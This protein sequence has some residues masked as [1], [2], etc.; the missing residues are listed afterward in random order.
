[1]ERTFAMKVFAVTYWLLAVLFLYI[2][3]VLI[4]PQL[5]K[6][7]DQV[8]PFLPL[9]VGFLAIFVVGAAIATFW[10]GARRRDWIWLALLVPPALFL[11][12]NAPFIPFS[13]THPADIA[14]TAVV[15]LVIGTIVLVWA[16]VTAFREVRSGSLASSSGATRAR[17]AVAVVAGFTIGA[18]ATG[19]LASTA[20]GGGGSVVAAPTTTATLVA[21]GTKYLTTS[22]A[23]TASDV[24]GIFVENKD[25]FAHSFDIDA[26]NLHV[27]IAAN[28]TVALSVKPAGAGS[29]EFY[30]AVPGHKEAG[31]AGTINVQ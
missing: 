11:L 2:L 15:P 4:L 16:G 3:V 23:M 22:Y 25:S 21:L 24:L 12:M 19:Y 5:A 6:S 27:Q 13:V 9:I 17:V 30:C 29:L 10:G 20:A 18:F 28:S 1:M 26:L 31:M 8:G 14:F 7:P